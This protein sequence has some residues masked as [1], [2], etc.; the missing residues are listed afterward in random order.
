MYDGVWPLLYYDNENNDNEN[1]DNDKLCN[2]KEK[3]FLLHVVNTN[4]KGTWYTRYLMSPWK[5]KKCVK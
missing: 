5:P 2:D 1:N 3:K 4:V